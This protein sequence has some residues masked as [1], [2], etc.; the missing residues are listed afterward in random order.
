[1]YAK[2][3]ELNAMIGISKKG[4]IDDFALLFSAAASTIRRLF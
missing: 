4:A 3:E 2:P 1:V